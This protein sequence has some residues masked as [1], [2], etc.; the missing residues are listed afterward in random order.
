MTAIENK[1]VQTDVLIIGGGPAGMWSAK[2][3]KELDENLGIIIV[4]KGGKWGGQMTISGGDFDAVLPGEDVSDWVKDL[5]YYYDGLCEQDIVE[6][7]FSLSYDRMV[8]YQEL[9]CTFLRKKDGSLKVSSA[10]AEL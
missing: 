4:D 1:L 3:L 6:K 8:E 2:R 10:Q 5:I 7:L 9:G